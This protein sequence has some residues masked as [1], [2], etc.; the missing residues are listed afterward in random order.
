MNLQSLSEWK[1]EASS[2]FSNK[3][4][5]IE[6]PGFLEWLAWNLPL[7]TKKKSCLTSL[8]GD[9]KQIWSDFYSETATKNQE[10]T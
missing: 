3:P 9:W 4:M 5:T 2:V 8:K 7:K 6:N 10:R 1:R